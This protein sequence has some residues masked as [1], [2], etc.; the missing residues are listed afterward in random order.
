M[1]S[2]KDSA[3]ALPSD[4]YS[5]T[6]PPISDAVPQAAPVLPEHLTRS[7]VMLSSL[8]SIATNVDGI[9]RQFYGSGALPT[10][11]IILPG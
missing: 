11:R 1:P 4:R 5:P 7:T 9:V 3:I 10:R 8:P 6:A 2:L